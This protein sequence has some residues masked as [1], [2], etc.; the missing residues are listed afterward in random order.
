MGGTETLILKSQRAKSR[1]I[2]SSDSNRTVQEL[3][4]VFGE[5]S[6]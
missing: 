5:T 6:W 4:L 2:S 1:M 3:P